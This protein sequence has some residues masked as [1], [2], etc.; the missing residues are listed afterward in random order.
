MP[1]GPNGERR[2]ADPIE[3]AVMVGRIATEQIEDELPSKRRNGGLARAKNLSKERL[4]EIGRKGYDAR[5]VA[6]SNRNA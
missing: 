5:R 2:P 6:E 3:C 1:R 4:S